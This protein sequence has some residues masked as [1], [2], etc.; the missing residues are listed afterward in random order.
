MDLPTSSYLF[1][2]AM[3]ST[4][5]VGFAALLVGVRQAK[6]GAL[7]KYDAYFT[8]AFI[9]LGFIVAACGFMPP[10]VALY[11]VPASVVWRVSGVLAATAILLFVVTVPR[12]RRMATG[13]PVPLFVRTILTL[14]ATAAVM[15]LLS[16]AWAPAN[17]AAIYSTAVTLVL[18]TSAVAYLYVLEIIQPRI[19]QRD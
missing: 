12:R 8:E 5:Y 7:T 10:L 4:T 3:V 2:L 9:Q 1:S 15:L 17:A 18:F 19:A 11:G 6:G 16:A 13:M 14:Q